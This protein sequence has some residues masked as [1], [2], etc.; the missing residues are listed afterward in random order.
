MLRCQRIAG[1]PAG[2]ALEPVAVPLLARLSSRV[3]RPTGGA[4]RSTHATDELQP[5]RRGIACS[6]ASSEDQEAPDDDG[7]QRRIKRDAL[8][9]RLTQ[10]HDPDNAL[11]RLWEAWARDARF[12]NDRFAF[13]DPEYTRQD[14]EH[15]KEGTMY[16]RR[17]AIRDYAY[18]VPS[19]E[20]LDVIAQESGGRVVEVGAGTGYWAWLLSR[21][22]VDVVA[23]DTG[24]EM[25][26]QDS[27]AARE[28]LPF[29]IGAKRYFP[30]MQEC[31]GPEF[32]AR[33]G[34]CPDRALLMCWVSSAVGEASLA[35]YRGDTV[36]A[37]GETDMGC[38]WEL[39]TEE[40]PEW[41]QV[42]YV[43]LP[44]WPRI[45]DDMRVYRRVR[46]VDGEEEGKR[47]GEEGEE[48]EG[49]EGEGGEGEEGEEGEGEGEEVGEA[50]HQ[51]P[52]QKRRRRPWRRLQWRRSVERVVP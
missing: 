26:F 51:E 25:F 15:E 2:L 50:S 6:A 36:V 46:P 40:H 20:A 49:E 9:A 12:L 52:Q 4:L 33:H 3:A 8:F 29:I 1:S 41:R 44:Q 17:V 10:P 23:V 32:L 18:A 35:A 7:Q 13:F 28:A 21:R 37:V 5:Q 22:G 30:E 16:M 31:D 43:P 34:G 38:T 39:N 45:R 14:N 48:G 27:P 24:G 47:E 42:R 11:L 19:A